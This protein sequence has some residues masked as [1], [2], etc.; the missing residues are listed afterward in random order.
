M[1]TD[2]QTL[3]GLVETEIER[4][5]ESARQNVPAF[6]TEELSFGAVLLSQ[7]K[8]LRFDAWPLTL[9]FILA[10][11]TLV[12]R[13]TANLAEKLGYYGLQ[14][15]LEKIPLPLVT[16]YE[17]A[18]AAALERRVFGAGS[19]RDTPL[20]KALESMPAIEEAS[21]LDFLRRDAWIRSEV[22]RCIDRWTSVRMQVV[23][24]LSSVS[25]VIGSYAFFRRDENLASLSGPELAARQLHDMAVNDFFL[26]RALGSVFYTF[27]PVHPTVTQSVIATA[28]T[29]GLL[30]LLTFA[31][32]LLSDPLQRL[33][34]SQRRQLLRAIDEV[35][36][37][38]VF[39]L[40]RRLRR[41]AKATGR[42]FDTIDDVLDAAS[43]SGR[44][45]LGATKGVF[46]RAGARV[47]DEWHT[48]ANVVGPRVLALLFVVYY[49]GIIVLASYA[50]ER[51][52]NERLARARR[53]V[54]AGSYRAALAETDTLLRSG[55]FSD[56]IELIALRARSFCGIGQV[57]PCA[58][59]YERA[60][61]LD[62]RYG[63]DQDTIDTL[64]AALVETGNFYPRRVIVDLIGARVV[65]DLKALALSRR[66]LKRWGL[67][68]ALEQ[69][70]ETNLPYVTYLELDLQLAHR[71][72]DRIEVIETV[73]DFGRPEVVERLRDLLAKPSEKCIHA[74]IYEALKKL[75]PQR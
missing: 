28:F 66:P 68:K 49:G 11:P 48:M 23:G 34:G 8:H 75:A 27:A 14:A 36:E 74:A 44:I 33:I 21:D 56:S 6:L 62:P 1:T 2:H 18:M 17:R 63:M 37:R 26:G 24:A 53:L 71:C 41:S 47:V 16:S 59:A 40:K 45:V 65:P 4:Y 35:E 43:E 72:K 7:L 5:I 22:T 38:L 46:G 50:I 20:L 15:F 10:L 58:E 64:V 51:N 57:R 39:S 52:L 25:V 73:A 60:I 29:V 70:G 30:A 61:R 3:R 54:H 69:L 9:N 55:R 13:R 32:N 31:V 19:D 42:R 12:V 67:A